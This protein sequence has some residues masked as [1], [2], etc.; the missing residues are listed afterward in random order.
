MLNL[1][2]SG[3]LVYS[4]SG[5]RLWSSRVFLKWR[6]FVEFLGVHEVETVCGV[7]VCSRNGDCLWSF[8]VFLKWRPFVELS[9]VPEIETVC[10]VLV[11]SWSEDCLWSSCVFIQWR[12]FAEFSCIPEMETICGVLMCSWSGD[13]SWSFRVFLKWRP[14]LELLCVPEVNAVRSS[15]VFMKWRPFLEF[16]FV[17][18]VETVFGVLVCSRSRDSFRSIRAFQSGDRFRS[19]RVFLLGWPFPECGCFFQVEDTRCTSLHACAWI[20]VSPFQ[21]TSQRLRDTT[22]AARALRASSASAKIEI[23]KQMY[24]QCRNVRKRV[25]T[26]Q[27]FPSVPSFSLVFCFFSLARCPDNTVSKSRS[28]RRPCVLQW[29]GPVTYYV[30]IMRSWVSGKLCVLLFSNNARVRYNDYN[31]Y[32]SR[33]RCAE[34]FHSMCCRGHGNSQPDILPANRPVSNQ[35]ISKTK[36]TGVNQKGDY[37][38]L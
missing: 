36:K 13:H 38:M 15:R 12:P 8:R 28:R 21:I 29:L 7:I 17:P 10:G 9:C 23:R 30:F 14:F 31:N 5:D 35:L 16:S 37:P 33:I 11:Y 4:W 6:P 24:K 20:L 34:L 32:C 25:F 1:L 19:S 18:E 27:K 3:V 2:N 22:G 26:K